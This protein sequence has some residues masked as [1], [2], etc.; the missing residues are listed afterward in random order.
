M[1]VHSI[2]DRDHAGKL[3]RSLINY[4]CAFPAHPHA[5]EDTAFS[6]RSASEAEYACIG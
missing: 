1:D 3:A 5:T 6:I 2:S 4:D